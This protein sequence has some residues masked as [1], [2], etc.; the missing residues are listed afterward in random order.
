MTVTAEAAAVLSAAALVGAYL[1]TKVARTGLVAAT[2]LCAAGAFGLG[3]GNVLK[4]AYY[5]ND[6][7]IYHQDPEHVSAAK[8]KLWQE[9]FKHY[10]EQQALDEDERRADPPFIRRD[11]S[12]PLGI[13]LLTAGVIWACREGHHACNGR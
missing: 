12:V 7:S 5:P 4:R 10:R 2:A 13:V 11:V 3:Q 8:L 9:K 1:L 6:P